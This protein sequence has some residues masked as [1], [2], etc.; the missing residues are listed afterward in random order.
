MCNKS[1]N[2]VLSPENFGNTMDPSPQ[3]LA[4]PSPGIF[5]PCAYLRPVQRRNYNSKSSFVDCIL[6]LL[7]AKPSIKKLHQP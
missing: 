2:C 3:K 1:K 6:K 5:N 7:F 4:K